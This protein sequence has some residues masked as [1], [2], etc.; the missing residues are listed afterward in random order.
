SSHWYQS[1]LDCESLHGGNSFDILV[2]EREAVLLC[3]HSWGDHDHPTILHPEITPGNGL[4]LYFRTDNLAGIRENA[5]KMAAPV[6]EEIHRNPNSLKKEFSL[7]DPDG[8]F[9]IISE[10]HAY[11]G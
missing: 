11:K 7:R 3:L 8:Y 2:D 4:I 1:L 5:A 6:E 10:L 9:L